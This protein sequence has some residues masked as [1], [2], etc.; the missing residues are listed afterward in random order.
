[1][2][3]SKPAAAKGQPAASPAPKTA[4][5]A[6]GN[7]PP[8]FRKIDWLTFLITTLVV[9]VGYFYTLAPDLTLEDS[10]ELAVASQYAG[11]PHPPGYPVWTIYTW[12]WTVLLPIKNIAWR[13]ALGEATAGAFACGLLGFVVAFFNSI[14]I[15]YAIWRS[16]KD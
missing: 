1:M 14:W 7:P 10:G 5:P 13:V 6:T 11:I 12:L 3:K 9:W 16:G 2:D 15:L 8:L 4:S